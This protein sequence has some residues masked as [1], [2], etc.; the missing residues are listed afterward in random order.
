MKYLMALAVL[1][2]LTTPAAAY[3]F[4]CADVRSAIDNM[5]D[6]TIRGAKRLAP[7]DDVRKACR[8]VPKHPACKGIK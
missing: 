1:A 5:P 3:E 2:T 6:S 7:S 8:C 4:T